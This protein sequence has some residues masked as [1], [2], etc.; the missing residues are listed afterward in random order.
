MSESFFYKSIRRTIIQFLGIFNDINI[1]RYDSTGL[2]TG[3]YK[4]PIRYGPKTKAYLWVKDLS[5][6]EEMLP[7]ISVYLTGIDFDPNR[8]SNKFQDILINK[9]G[10]SGTYAKNA[11][12]YNISFTVNLWTLHMVD[13]DQIFEQILP[14]FIPHA[15]IKVRIP[16]IDIL[17]DV[18]VMCN[19]CSPVM[20]DDIG[21]DEARIIKWDVTFLVQTWLFKPVVTKPLIG[22]LEGTLTN[23]VSWT[24]GMGTAGFGNSGT[25]GKIVNRYYTDLDTFNSRD[26]PIKE[27]YDD[28]RISEVYAFRPIGVDEEAKLI[29]DYETWGEA[30]NV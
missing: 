23:G 16:E 26:I 20:T 12:P 28:S 9:D 11:I 27:I 6:N 10:G 24:S 22:A 17:F 19:G 5:R 8:L 29:I 3:T 14:F 15:F 13:V 1:E 21:E 2:V 30:T 18:K 4:V 25:T 7:M